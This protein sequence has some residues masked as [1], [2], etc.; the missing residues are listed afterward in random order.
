[1]GCMAE[2]LALQ[3]DKRGDSSSIPAQVKLSLEELR[4]S[5]NTLLVILN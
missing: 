3:T 5:N 1:M 2:W 4:V